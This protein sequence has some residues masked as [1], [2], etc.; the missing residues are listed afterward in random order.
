MRTCARLVC[1]FTLAAAPAAAQTTT[2]DGIRAM[3]RGDY[4]T[5]ARILR[6]LAD[7]TLRPDPVAQFFLAFLYETGE[8]VGR[9][10]SRASS[11]IGLRI[12]TAR[13]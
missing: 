1:V 5:A 3:V 2:E 13:A 11:A 6:P 9:D 8:G 12:S 4:Q 7:D 10:E